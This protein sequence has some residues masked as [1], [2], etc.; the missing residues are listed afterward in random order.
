MSVNLALS[1]LTFNKRE[2]WA[3]ISA[4]MLRQLP[5]ETEISRPSPLAHAILFRSLYERIPA[6]TVSTDAAENIRARCLSP[7]VASG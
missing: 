7:V 4:T 3:Y 2:Q 6:T 1:L 5:R